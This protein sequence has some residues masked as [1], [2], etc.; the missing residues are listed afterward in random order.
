MPGRPETPP[1][2]ERRTRTR[3]PES[4]R[5]PGSGDVRSS[6][7]LDHVA[8]TRKDRLWDLQAE[9]LRRL[10][11]D[12]QIELPRVRVRDPR[13]RASR[14]DGPSDLSR[15]PSDVLRARERQCE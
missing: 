2:S 1:R 7:S 3:A 4:W 5:S 12:G 9:L 11:V 6:G 13:R 14:E 8:G 15:L 10:T